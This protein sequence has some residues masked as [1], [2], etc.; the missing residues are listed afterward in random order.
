MS[1]EFQSKYGIQLS[2]VSTERA[3]TIKVTLGKS[4]TNLDPAL[5]EQMYSIE[6][7]DDV[8]I[9]RVQGAA[10]FRNALMTLEQLVRFD[11]ANGPAFRQARIYDYP[12]MPFRGIHFF[13][14]KGARD[15]QKKMVS[16]ILSPLKINKL[17]YQVD[18]IKWD[19][20]PES[21]SEAYGMEKADAKAVADAA[22]ER[23][24]DVIPLVN[25]FGHSEWLLQNQ[26]MRKYADD[27]A[28]PFAYDPSNPN[29][30]KICE[31][32]YREAIDLFHPTIVHIGHDEVADE[33]F[34]KKAANKK[35]GATQLLINDILHYHR[36]LHRLGIR[37]MMWGDTLL[38]PGEAPDA[39]TAPGVDEAARRRSLLP[40]DIL[41]SDWHYKAVA[42]SD[43]KS[44]KTFGE[45]GFDTVAS[46]WATPANIVHFAEA[47]QMDY[48]T[49]HSRGLLQTTWAGY[50][51][52]QQSLSN[53]LD[54]YAAYVLAAEAAWTGGATDPDELPF[55]YKQEFLRRWNGET[56]HGDVI[57]GW[58]CDG[59][60]KVA[61]V[62]LSPEKFSLADNALEDLHPGYINLG[63]YRF[64]LPEIDEETAAIELA[65]AWDSATTS[66]DVKLVFG[67]RLIS[68]KGTG[69]GETSAGTREV[70]M[71]IATPFSAPD[72]TVAGTVTFGLDDGLTH[73]RDLVYGQNIMSLSDSRQALLSPIA[74]K[75][76]S[77][78]PGKGGAAIRILNWKNPTPAENIGFLQL[79]SNAKG[80]GL[81]LF[82]V[83]GVA[84]GD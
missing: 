60:D 33:G 35:V 39:T 11:Q 50:S 17:V 78:A 41:I 65:G 12:S 79:H 4:A 15:L 84:N 67:D 72:G 55:D 77:H 59:L 31:S 8:Q 48:G 73:T 14:G 81:L 43:Y 36:F 62:Q 66:R 80:P 7:A 74:W 6:I 5:A 26:A 52:D 19:T 83:S 71:A 56:V 75:S 34:P 38:A 70:F 23:G 49:S 37:T 27:P 53:N 18:Y 82:G 64:R 58:I 51:F 42:P 3:A 30:Y 28:D 10:G 54:Q 76:A 68:R 44:L 47:A 1:A 2:K 13:T 69:D 32:I 61:N 57:N 45:A 20:A 40:K 16:E 29:V 46:T 9:K 63:R 25:T 21:N 24:I 22:K